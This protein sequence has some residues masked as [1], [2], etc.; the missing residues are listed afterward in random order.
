MPGGRW[1][2][3]DREA[4]STWVAL[5]ERPAAGRGFEYSAAKAA[6]AQLTRS[7]AYLLDSCPREFSPKGTGVQP[8]VAD[9]AAS[10][11]AARATELVDG[12]QPIVSALTPEDV[13]AA[14]LWLAGGASHLITGQ[15][16]G[17][18]PVYRPVG[19]SP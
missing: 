5:R 19:P 9:A 15:D 16:L 4:S 11:L 2:L 12:I 7:A 14:V 17:S 13:A 18:T 10:V 3:G 1:P 8:S 6:V